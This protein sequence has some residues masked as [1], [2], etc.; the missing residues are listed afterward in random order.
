MLRSDCQIRRLW[1]CRV[2]ITKIENLAP[3]LEQCFQIVRCVTSR[4]IGKLDKLHAVEHRYFELSGE[5]NN[6]KSREFIVA[7]SKRLNGNGNGCDFE[8]DVMRN[9]KKPSSNER[10]PTV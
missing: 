9:S 3:K 7:D 2:K 4:D 5:T 8:S 6:F 10:W 1:K